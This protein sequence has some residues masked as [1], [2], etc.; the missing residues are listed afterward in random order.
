MTLN[1][2]D[3]SLDAEDIISASLVSP[4]MLE[5]SSGS[6]LG[7]D[8]TSALNFAEEMDAGEVS[9]VAEVVDVEE[10]KGIQQDKPLQCTNDVDE[11]EDYS[12]AVGSAVVVGLITLPFHFVIATVA[13]GSAA[14][15]S[16]NQDGL[17][18][19]ICRAAG[20]VA[21]A[22]RDK[23]VEVNAE[24]NIMERAK[25]RTGEAFEYAQ[26][27]NNRHGYVQRFKIGIKQAW[28][29]VRAFETQHH[30]VARSARAISSIVKAAAES[31][32]GDKEERP[33]QENNGSTKNPKYTKV[34][35]P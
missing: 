23:A 21:L 20:D 19:D 3:T 10:R 31:F 33:S 34:A 7:Q 4:S 2:N 6:V 12:R 14:Y 5:S 35:T 28:Q 32:S 18:G 13:A 16:R 27:E 30:L 11:E 9:V 29:K 22:A 24:H 1:E 15:A 25:T 17:A 26:E 8:R